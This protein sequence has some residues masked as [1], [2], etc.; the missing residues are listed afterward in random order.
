MVVCAF[1]LTIRLGYD[2]DNNLAPDCALFFE[3]LCEQ[4]PF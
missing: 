1:D 2:V 3:T 4:L